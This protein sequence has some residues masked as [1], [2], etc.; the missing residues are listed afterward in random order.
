MFIIHHGRTIVET[1]KGRKYVKTL[2]DGNFFGKEFG[3]IC[4]SES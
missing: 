3:S 4:V 2:V 1:L